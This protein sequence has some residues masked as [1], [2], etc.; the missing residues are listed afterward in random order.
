MRITTDPEEAARALADGQVVAIPTET[1]YGLGAR[2]DSPDAVARVY[3]AK[4][5]PADHPLIVHVAT[6]D[7]VTTWTSRMPPYAQALAAAYWPG[8]LTL[9]L[10][11]STRAGDFITG[12]QDTVAVRVPGNALTREVIRRVGEIVDD[13]HVGIAAPSANRFGR[14]SPTRAQDVV[15]ELGELLDD[16]LVLDGGPSTVGVESTIVDCSGERPVILRPGQIS[17]EDIE[18]CTGLTC[19]ATSD[20]RAPGTL[21][22]HYSPAAQVHVIDADSIPAP[23]PTGSG[24]I[25]LSSIP[26]PPGMVRLTAPDT[27][28]HYAASLY[29]AL[30]EADALE[31]G[32]VYAIPPEGEGVEAA[33]RDRLS[34]AAHGTT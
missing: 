32:T 5:R 3:A 10:P 28:A 26:T 22:A 8:P 16:E 18:V 4:G 14:V 31:L 15:A 2:A 6:A 19:A 9:V 24:L 17:R 34:R 33:I 21:A 20:V 29:R 11:R 25:A 13:P 27:A 1:V 30:R 23:V 7:A 12:T